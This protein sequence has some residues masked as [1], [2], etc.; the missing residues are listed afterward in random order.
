MTVVLY[1]CDRRWRYVVSSLFPFSVFLPVSFH[2]SFPFSLPTF[3]GP[4]SHSLTNKPTKQRTGLQQIGTIRTD[5][6]GVDLSHFQW[7]TEE[8]SA[9][10]STPKT[11]KT[12]KRVYNFDFYLEVVLRHK[13]GTVLFRVRALGGGEHVD[14][15]VVGETGV[16]FGG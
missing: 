13:Q 11:P 6:L 12:L 5:L 7:R 14:G 3:P 4:K 1:S 16:E 8:S 10:G 9:A 2:P 15:K